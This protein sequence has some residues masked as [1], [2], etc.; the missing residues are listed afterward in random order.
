[1]RGNFSSVCCSLPAHPLLASATLPPFMS[2]T[3]ARY[4]NFLVKNVSTISTLESSL[5]SITWF[6]PGRFKDADLVSE[7]CQSILLPT[8]LI[9]NQTYSVAVSALLNTISLY[10]DTLLTRIVKSDPQWRPILPT[11]LHTKY[12]RAW[13]DKDTLY[14]WAARALE[15]IRFSQLLVEM[16][17]RRKLR[18][19]AR[20][21]G[22]V[23]MET[24][25]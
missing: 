18:L 20:W 16:V 12:T 19:R 7:A 6:L 22:L 21:R 1:M 5:R 14:K 13:S 11:P 24:V 23:L 25:K 2:L 15:L 3:L 10:H 9:Y 8:C 17:M 4:E